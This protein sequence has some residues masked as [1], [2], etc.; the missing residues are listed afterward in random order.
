MWLHLRSALICVALLLPCGA[1]AQE[2]N[3]S[4]GSQSVAPAPGLPTFY[5]HSRQ[6]IVEAEVGNHV[7]KKNAG[8]ASWIPQGSLEGSP[9]GGASLG[10]VLKLLPPPAHGL[11]AKDFHVFDDGVEQKINYF[12]E[13][14][15][16]AVAISTTVSW[17]FDP[18]ARGIWGTTS[19]LPGIL[20]APSATYLIGYVPPALQPGECR[21]IQIV[22][23]NHYIQTNRKQYCKAEKADA[24]TTAEET[25]LAARME[26]FASSSKP[27]AMN[28]SVRTFTFWSSGVLSLARETPLAGNTTTNAPVLPATDFTY[29]VEV[30]DS[31]APAT[32]QIT[33]EF[34]LPYQLWDYPCRKSSAIH[35]LGMVYK[36]NGELERQFGD[37]FRCDMRARILGG[38]LLQKT[39][40][41]KGAI[42]TLFDTQ[43]ELRPGEYELRVV[44]TD[45]KQFGRARLPFRVEALNGTGLTVSDV[46]LNSI[47]RDA[48]WVVRDAASV[49][50]APLVP[51]PLV[52]KNVQ[53]L[54]V[55]DA[56]LR[57]DNPLSV[58]F[59]IYKPPD[60]DG[61]A[62]YY[63]MRITDL[64]TGATVMNT[65]PISAAE[66]VVPGNGVV[67][68]GLKLNTDKL[69]P[70]TY[71]LEVRA[72]DS[73]G[74]ESEWRQ[75]T[76]TI[77]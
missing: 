49:T 57:K 12:K 64:K 66:F 53:F 70:G 75:A 43:I 72:S 73:V 7:D 26:H 15:F 71:R 6:V 4:S 8:D 55:A 77:G 1:N 47:L 21:T 3:A 25:K 23:P 2:P 34:G 58:Y 40:G 28:V 65:E 48:S 27:G 20:Y 19:G 61:N 33:T 68:V 45:G 11:A 35:V 17:R 69:E 56:Q 37:T 31:K 59:E 63:R 30:H 24:A 76:F 22:V 54:P 41:V 5:A 67:P 36:T 52:S 29:I 74:R 46:A 16:P 42:P 32:V 13:A 62:V 9:D 44:V 60:L 10:K 18:T 38:E 14:D 50:P 39:P 51:T